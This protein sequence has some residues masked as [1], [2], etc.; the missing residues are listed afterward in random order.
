MGVDDVR[1]EA[2]GPHGLQRGPTE[3]AEA[4]PVVRIVAR[5][6]PV[7]L[8]PVEVFRPV[9]EIRRDA[10]GAVGQ[11]AIGERLAVHFERRAV[12]D[13]RERQVL[14]PHLP[15]E[16]HEDPDVRAQA[17]E[18]LGEGAGHVGQA[19]RLGVGDDF[20]SEECDF[21]GFGYSSTSPRGGHSRRCVASG[22]IIVRRGD[23]R[24]TP[25]R[26]FSRSRPRV[27]GRDS[28]GRQ[29][30]LPAARACAKPRSNTFCRF[31][32]KLPSIRLR[33]G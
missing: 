7:Q 27:L 4:L 25:T 26:Y 8:V 5:R 18:E 22:I 24:R 17:G 31:P 28:A 3:E 16:G 2:D 13:R 29:E 11:D 19:A 32:G 33:T 9:D 20:G 10:V 30:P 15:V 12:D 23:Y 21:H 1:G 6:R 14:F